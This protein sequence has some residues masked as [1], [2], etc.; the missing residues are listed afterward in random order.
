MILRSTD[1]GHVEERLAAKL[2]SPPITSNGAVTIQ[3]LR[4]SAHFRARLAFEARQPLR[5]CVRLEPDGA[6]KIQT[7]TVLSTKHGARKIPRRRERS[8]LLVGLEK[9][10]S[11]GATLANRFNNLCA[12][13]DIAALGASN[14][15]VKDITS[16]ISSRSRSAARMTSETFNCSVRAVTSRNT[17]RILSYG[18]ARTGDFFNRRL[19]INL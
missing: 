5:E 4:T 12:G 11:E 1:G 10:R 9:R 7:V 6:R 8:R 14:R 18:R 13:S 15:S 2:A 3:K 17:R 19:A 16:I